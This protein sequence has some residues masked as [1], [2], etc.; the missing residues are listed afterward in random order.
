MQLTRLTTISPPFGLRSYQGVIRVYRGQDGNIDYTT[1]VADMGIDES[2]V[3]IAGQDLP[4]NTIWHYTRRQVSGCGLES[5]DSPV[6]R[7]AIDAAGDMV[8]STPNAPQAL[9]IEQLI[10]GKLRLRWRYIPVD[11]EILPTGFYIY[12]DTGSGFDFE[13][14]YATV[15]Y[16]RRWEFKWDSSALTHGTLYRFVVRAYRT[17]GGIDSN[18]RIVSALA[19]SQGPAALTGLT[20]SWEEI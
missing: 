17:G 13:T 6:C 10:G 16:Q 11:Q 12:I 7:V 14:P 20:A 15:S 18:T 19:D 2:Q 8:G 9:A 5:D 3:S 1:P 4:A